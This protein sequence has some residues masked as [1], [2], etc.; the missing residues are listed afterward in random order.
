MNRLV[1]SI[2]ALVVL[3]F[4]A[5]L[6]YPVPF[7]EPPAFAELQVTAGLAAFQSGR[8]HR[9]LVV[10]GVYLA[11]GY[12]R[13]GGATLTC[14]G[15]VPLEGVREAKAYWYPHPAKW[16]RSTTSLL[17]QLEAPPGNVVLSYATQKARLGASQAR[18]GSGEK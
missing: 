2:T 13:G 17:M 1:L 15:L 10:G 3:P 18:Q 11:C 7:V 8:S 14:D 16:P 9:N 5:W 6:A 4:A 12:T